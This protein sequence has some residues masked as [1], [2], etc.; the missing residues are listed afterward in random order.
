MCVLCFRF[1]ETNYNIQNIESKD[2]PVRVP[3]K[4]F[5]ECLWN[6]GQ[7]LKCT[8]LQTDQESSRCWVMKQECW[9][10]LVCIPRTTQFDPC[11]PWQL[12]LSPWNISWSLAVTRSQMTQKPPSLYALPLSVEFSWNIPHLQKQHQLSIIGTITIWWNHLHSSWYTYQRRHRGE[13]Q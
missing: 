10:E 1:H 13:I 3:G 7:A 6:G 5:L 11:Y 12:S 8:L 2:S 4:T 9:F